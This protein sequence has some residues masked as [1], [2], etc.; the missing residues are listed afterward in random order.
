M[1]LCIETI[2]EHKT[3][4][5]EFPNGDLEAAIGDFTWNN[6]YHVLSIIGLD[7]NKIG[8][9]HNNS[10]HECDIFKLNNLILDLEYNFHFD[11]NDLDNL[12]VLNALLVDRNYDVGEVGDIIRGDKLRIYNDVE[13]MGDVAREFLDE[14]SSWYHEARKA[15]PEINKYF[16][17]KSYGEEILNQSNNFI[18]IKDN[19]IIV[20]VYE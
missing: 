11:P 2:E 20:E 6:D 10:F 16:D 8:T 18:Q 17:F 9:F 7:K 12:A 3:G 14:T 5:I 1:K 19:K 15:F 13:D 4:W